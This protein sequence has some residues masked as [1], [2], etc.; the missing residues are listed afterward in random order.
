MSEV[1]DYIEGGWMK[2]VANADT[3]DIYI[4]GSLVGSVPFSKFYE[5]ADGRPKLTTALALGDSAMVFAI[6]SM[7]GVDMRKP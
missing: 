2:P 3:L 7:A 4:G 6:L 5:A 1:L